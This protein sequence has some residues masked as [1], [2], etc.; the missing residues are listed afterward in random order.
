MFREE[1]Q[2]AL[3]FN[4]NDIEQIIT[5]IHHRFLTIYKEIHALTMAMEVHALSITDPIF[6]PIHDKVQRRVPDMEKYSILQL[7]AAVIRLANS[8]DH[9]LQKI[10]MKD[11]D[12]EE[13]DF[14]YIT[15]KPCDLWNISDDHYY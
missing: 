2:D 8:E 7:K 11:K 13:G 9:F 10:F 12:G 6:T 5:M 14:N 15:F 4:D 3:D 1:D